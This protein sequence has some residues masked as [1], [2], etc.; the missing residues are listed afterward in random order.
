MS[1]AP[2]D[3]KQIRLKLGKEGTIQ[4]TK[5]QFG[6][7]N[8]NKLLVIQ[9]KQSRYIYTDTKKRPERISQQ[10]RGDNNKCPVIIIENNVGHHP[11][12]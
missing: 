6:K 12:Q 11:I 8:E 7:T 9:T 10:L 2:L 1:Q 3:L 5:K 4:N